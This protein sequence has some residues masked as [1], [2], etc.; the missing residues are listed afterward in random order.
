VTT[1]TPRHLARPPKVVARSSEVERSDTSDSK[2]KL[3]LQV[4][5]TFYKKTNHLI[6]AFPVGEGG[7]TEYRR[8]RLNFGYENFSNVSD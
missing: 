5:P 3:K 2:V 7:C 4:I 8:M 1:T 6:I